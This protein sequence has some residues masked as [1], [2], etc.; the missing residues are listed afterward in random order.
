M[1]AL[2]ATLAGRRA[3]ESLMLDHGTAKRPN[4]GKWSYNPVSGN[5]EQATTDLFTSRCKVASRALVAR[6]VEVGG[7]TATSV[8][9]ELHLPADTDPLEVGDLFTVTEV[10]PTSLS[11]VGRTYRVTGLADGTF[12]TAA[13]YEVEA[14]A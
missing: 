14:T 5:E 6:E 13:R 9:L 1:S 8:R 3:A 12:R 2:S 4:D 10:A 11:Q 7:R